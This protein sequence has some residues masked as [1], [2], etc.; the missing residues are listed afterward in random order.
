MRNYICFVI[1][2]V[3]YSGTIYDSEGTIES[4]GYPNS[5]SG[6]DQWRLRVAGANN[7]HLY[8]HDIDQSLQLDTINFSLDLSLLFARNYLLTNRNFGRKLKC[9][10]KIE[11]SVQN[12]NV[13]AKTFWLS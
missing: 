11:I 10:F 9:W 2:T 13:G 8:F 4:D 5:Y 6:S 1:F 12:Q 3:A 7:Y